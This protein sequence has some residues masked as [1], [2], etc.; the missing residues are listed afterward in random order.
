MVCNSSRIS[1]R[2]L[3]KPA[4]CSS[5]TAVEDRFFTYAPT[6][7]FAHTEAASSSATVLPVPLSLVHMCAMKLSALNILSSGLANEA[8]ISTRA[9]RLLFSRLIRFTASSQVS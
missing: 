8:A 1:G 5:A 4:L 2:C 9:G 7:G 3:V 6:A